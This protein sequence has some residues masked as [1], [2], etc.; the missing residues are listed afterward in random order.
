VAVSVRIERIAGGGAGVA[1]HDGETWFVGGALPGET[2][3][4]EI[5]RRRAGVVEGRTLAVLEAPHA[6]REPGP[7]PHAPTCGG[8]D[9]PYVTPEGGAALKREAAAG[10]ARGVPALAEQLLAAPVRSS[11]L[12]YRL[13][14]RLHWRPASADSQVGTLGFYSRRTWEPVEI[15][16]CR[17]ISPRL[18]AA[19]PRLAAALASTASGPVDVE[20]L[21]DLEGA[22]AVLALRPAR[23]GPRSVPPGWL[24]GAERLADVVEGGHLLSAAGLC[25]GG[26]GADH[27]VMGLPIP[28]EVP[29]GAFFQGN[30]YLVPWL[31]ENLGELAPT[32]HSP[33]WDL[34]AGVGL[35]AA[36]VLHRGAREAT[37]VEPYRPSARAAAR[38][39]PDAK[40]AVGRTAEAFLARHRRL[41]REA[42]AIT[43][44]PRAGLSGEL[45]SRLAGWHPE[46]IVML[47]CDP[48]TWARDAAFLLER[49]YELTHLE[50]VDLFPSTHHVEVLALLRSSSTS[51][52]A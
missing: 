18:A 37:L 33:V 9:W 28:L 30:R 46:T 26:W 36:A 15:P 8:C 17:I 45:R 35:L 19:I 3:S 48:A 52:E 34:H 27:V 38:N 50:L 40:V 2:V 16:S 5:T 42:L 11:P 23:D 7:C 44:P 25:S 49:G 14:S 4:A 1:H 32:G 21:E 13:R 39:L 10:A 51:G 22:T 43:D 31:F 6:A 24:P 12:G 41:P 20:W 29:I 47:G